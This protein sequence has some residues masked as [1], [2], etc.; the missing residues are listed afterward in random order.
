[1][2]LCWL[3]SFE[4]TGDGTGELLPSVTANMEVVFFLFVCF[5]PCVF[6]SLSGWQGWPVCNL[7]NALLLRAQVSNKTQ[8]RKS[9]WPQSWRNCAPK[10][11]A[12]D[13]CFTPPLCWLLLPEGLCWML[14]VSVAKRDLLPFLWVCQSCLVGLPSLPWQAPSG[15]VR[16]PA[17]PG[18]G[19]TGLV[20]RAWHVAGLCWWAR[21]CLALPFLAGR[22][23][24]CSVTS[25]LILVAL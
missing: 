21:R 12:R 3:V 13:G 17:S 8:S 25:L 10:S 14:G 5:F 15:V 6:W 19:G 1:M 9:L 23:H 11:S 20:R 22:C 4:L 16:L 24:G 2:A 7:I 18:S